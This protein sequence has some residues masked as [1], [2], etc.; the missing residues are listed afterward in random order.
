MTSKVLDAIEKLLQF[1]SHTKPEA[2]VSRDDLAP[3]L[4]ALADALIELDRGI[5]ADDAEIARVKELAAPKPLR[6]ND[7]PPL[8][9]R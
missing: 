8:A 6:P 7:K 5:K 3:V 1:G 4:T 9:R 2:P